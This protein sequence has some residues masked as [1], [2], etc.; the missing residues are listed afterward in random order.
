MFGK[1]LIRIALLIPVM[2]VVT[3][4]GYGQ[5][6]FPGDSIL[7]GIDPQ[8]PGILPVADFSVSG[9]DRIPGN[10][11]L[12]A[13]PTPL[14]FQNSYVVPYSPGQFRHHTSYQINDHRVSGILKNYRHGT[15][16]GAGGHNSLPG[17]STLN[18]ARMGYARVLNDKVSVDVQLH[19]TKW[20]SRGTGDYVLGSSGVFMYRINDSMRFNAFGSYFIQPS[21]GYRTY[22][23][24]GTLTVDITDRFGAE[25][26]VRRRY[27]SLYGK[28]ETIPVLKPYYKFNKFTLGAD[29]GEIMLYLLEGWIK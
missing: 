10:T 11:G 23:F 28:W 29:V 20:R 2:S 4:N 18:Y 3:L 9:T 13:E 6:N 16:Y 14:M 21:F 19:A 25:I 12:P 8:S 5:E 26:G 17:I 1:V 15:L 7:S 22:D 24:G 27:E